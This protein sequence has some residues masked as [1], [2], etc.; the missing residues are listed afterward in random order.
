LLFF[1]QLLCVYC[2]VTGI[3]K[4]LLI[5]ITVSGIH[6]FVGIFDVAGVPAVADFPDVAGL[7]S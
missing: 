5:L 1:L 7:P 3:S 4:S 2:N 6:A